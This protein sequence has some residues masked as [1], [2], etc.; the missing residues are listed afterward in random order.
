MNGEIKSLK[1]KLLERKWKI[2]VANILW[3]LVFV[4]VFF[5][6]VQLNLSNGHLVVNSFFGK[7]P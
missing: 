7:L 2:N 4:W 6:T 5:G 1:R 3:I